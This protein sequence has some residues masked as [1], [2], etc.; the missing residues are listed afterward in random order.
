[1]SIAAPIPCTTRAA[2]SQPIDPAKPHHSEAAVK[3]ASPDRYIERG[4][5]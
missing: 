4:P 3:T 5:N 2:I 1:M